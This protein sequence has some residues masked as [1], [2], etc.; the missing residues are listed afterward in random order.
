MA[1]YGA[2][3]E[4]QIKWVAL[5]TI[6]MFALA[7]F[8]A[9]FLSAMEEPLENIV[10]MAAIFVVAGLICGGYAVMVY[11][12]MSG[13]KRLLADGV[14]GTARISSLQ[15]TGRYMNEQPHVQLGLAV[16]TKEHGSYTTTHAEYVPMVMLGTLSSGQSIAVRVDRSDR[17]KL[18]I[19]WDASITGGDAT[20]N[21]V[22]GDVGVADLRGILASTGMA[23][24][25]I[26]TTMAQVQGAAPPPG[27]PPPGTPVPWTTP[28]GRDAIKA[29]VLATGTPGTATVLAA[30]PVG[31][32]DAEGLPVYEIALFVQVPG[33][34]PV[35]GAARVGVPLD[36]VA[37]VQQGATLPMKVDAGGP[38]VMAVDW[39]SA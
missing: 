15:Q 26:E 36:K 20:T 35:Q 5:I 6:L 3:Q 19:D 30:T 9:V 1:L 32:T 38:S 23:Q 29:R 27:A 34:Q 22:T 14:A 33:R 18:V 31:E 13:A 2:G 37:R 24:A 8:F 16:E 7:V 21:V 25:D 4:P 17:S 11:R 10:G 28:V 12:G 39:E